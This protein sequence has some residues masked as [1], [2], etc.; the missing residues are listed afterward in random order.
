MAK[1]VTKFKYLKPGK[2]KKGGYARYIA[3]REGVEK[4]DDSQKNEPATEKQQQF[5][6]KITV[7]YPEVK[8]LLE[9]EEYTLKPTVGNASELISRALEDVADSILNEKTYADY[10]ATRPRAQRFG[11]H[12]LFSDDGKPV[13]LRKVSHELNLHEGNVWTAIIS[14]RREDAERLGY[15]SG[16]RWRD[17]LRAHAQEFSEQFHI[18]MQ[19]LR[20]FAAFHNESHHPH[21][22]VI[23][24]STDTS[25]GF[26]AKSNVNNLRSSLGKEIFAQDLVCKYQEQTAHRD[27][28]RSESKEL[29]ANII[30]QINEGNFDNPVLESKLLELSKILSETGGKKVYGY[31]DADT[32]ALVDEIVDELADDERLSQLYELWYQ[33]KDFIHSTYTDEPAE[34]VP[35]SQNEEFKPIR[36]AVIREALNISE[37]R[38]TVEDKDEV[39]ESD[40]EPTDIPLDDS[41]EEELPPPRFSEFERLKKKAAAGNM[42]SQYT[43]AKLLLDRNSEHYEPETAV[44]WLKKSSDR[45]NAVAKYRLGK[46]FLLGEDV[47]QDTDE[48]LRW[49]NNASDDG[50]EYA[51]YLLGKLY[52]EGKYVEKDV[53]FALLYLERAAMQN[54]PYA[55]YLAGKLYLTDV[56]NRDTYRAVKC[57]SAA[58][59]NGN[60]YAEYM[61]GKM[62]LYGNGVER[63]VDLALSYLNSSAEHGNEYAAQL[64]YNL[65]HSKNPSVAMAAF[66]LLQ[67]LARIIQNRLEDERKS[68]EIQ[69]DK[70]LRRKIDEKR[71]AHGL[72]H[73]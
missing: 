51:Q 33:D 29:V 45:G 12:G 39:A 15:D 65:S 38:F 43:L 20:W 4:I 46:L 26:L 21:V 5:I 42:Y 18:P 56:E 31:L 28:L 13:N 23:I 57:F 17:M 59:E 61:L 30:A 68:K 64:L 60:S 40:E 3:T 52:A 22:H 66:R 53:F 11:A 69:T 48:A 34:R 2:K 37:D 8:E 16:E 62:Y 67:H 27:S 41:D 50:Y 73:G 24:Y 25:A 49:L 6:T 36:N 1:L 14:L 32:K 55:A 47:P 72:K 10:I 71:E 7:D 9:Y 19:N 70:K 63:N 35:L 54:N 58:A 44:E